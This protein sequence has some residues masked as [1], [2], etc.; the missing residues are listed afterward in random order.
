MQNENSQPSE[1]E[2]P[3][4]IALVFAGFLL[5]VLEIFMLASGVAGCWGGCSLDVIPKIVFLFFLAGAGLWMTYL[6]FS[7]GSIVAMLFIIPT[8]LVSGGSMLL[9]LWL[10]AAS[11]ISLVVK[12][13]S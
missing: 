2:G 6:V 11:A 8:S 7:A 1:E 12:V 4:A 3:P 10:F 13:F 9:V 5:I